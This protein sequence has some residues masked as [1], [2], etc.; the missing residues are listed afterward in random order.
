MAS[1]LTARSTQEPS[2]IALY[3][4]PY[5]G[6]GAARL[7]VERAEGRGTDQVGTLAIDRSVPALLGAGDA[8]LVK[9]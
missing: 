5:A 9:E 1:S 6:N 2:G 3:I 8:F 7:P 4:A